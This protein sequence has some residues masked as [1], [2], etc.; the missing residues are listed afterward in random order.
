MALL[1]DVKILYVW[2]LVTTELKD[3][4]TYW[5]WIEFASNIVGQSP[6]WTPV[7]KL[8]QLMKWLYHKFIVNVAEWPLLLY[9]H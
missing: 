1:F 6:V 7:E 8:N 2:V 9:R 3:T 5:Y 4:V